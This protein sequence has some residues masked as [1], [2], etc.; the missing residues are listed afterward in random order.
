M[1]ILI[2]TQYFHPE[3]FGINEVAYDLVG[4]GHA[5]T[6]LT[7][8]PNYPS[9]RIE[10]GY[11]GLRIRRE[12]IRGVSVVRVP[13]FPRGRASFLL[14]ALNY[15][16]FAV[17][18]SVLAP[19]L[20][21]GDTDVTLVYQVS[22]L[23]VGL[24]ALV[25]RFFKKVPIV[26]WV[27]DIWPETLI[28]V[29]S[30]KSTAVLQIIRWLA[31]FIY[32]RCYMILVQSPAYVAQI[33]LLGL[34]DAKIRYFPNAAPD[35]YRPVMPPPDAPER[36][37]LPNGFNVVFA[38]NIGL[39]QDFATILNGAELL[40]E[41]PEIHWVIIGDGRLRQ[42]VADEVFK[43]GLTDTFHLLG[44]LPSERMPTIFA[45]AD[46]LL[47]TLAPSSISG[48]TIPSKLQSYLACGRPV[49]G[50][51]DGEAGNI[52]L[53]SGAGIVCRPGDAPALAQAV[54]ALYNMPMAQRLVMGKAG[55]AY[56]EQEFE[57]GSLIRKLSDCLLEASAD[58]QPSRQPP[59]N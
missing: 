43:R 58:L 4:L 37:L 52:I 22:P 26:F 13:V 33:R 44:P 38:G 11:R 14:L 48:L 23:T 31:V 56:F 1:R 42:W 21:R 36:Q 35:H 6:V 34:H 5:V 15:L 59:A 25:L 18:A 30:V 12:V 8:M 32:K 39:Q 24:P 28:A 55:R 17:F 9:G 7:G 2:V 19:F 40:K 20:I 10:Q 51:V 54:D 3:N 49:V 41:T 46:A 45:L 47:V 16:S 29:K 53:R 50:V 57:R 27:Q